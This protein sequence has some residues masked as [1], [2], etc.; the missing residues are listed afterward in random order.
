MYVFACEFR[1]IISVLNAA[2]F[3][4]LFSKNITYENHLSNADL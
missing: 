4:I 1:K 3:A 2:D